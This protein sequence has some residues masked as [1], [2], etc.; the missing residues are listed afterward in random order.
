MACGRLYA[1]GPEFWDTK[2]PAQ[3]T[4]EEVDRLMTKSPWAKE[5]SASEQSGPGMP[6]LGVGG[7]GIGGG[8]GKRGGA[9]AAAGYKGAVVW[10]SA[11]PVRAARKKPLPD[12]FKD[13]YVIGVNG[14]SGQQGNFDQLKQFTTLQPKDQPIAQPGVVQYADESAAELLFGFSKDML[15]LS[16]D[17]KEIQFTTWFGRLQIRVKFITKEMT[18]KGKIA[19]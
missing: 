18:Y 1:S 9:P 17:D 13:H 4:S 3:W 7:I 16:A 15:D 19:L 5:V 10:E 2:D 8:R 11:E 14:A 12:A 6:R